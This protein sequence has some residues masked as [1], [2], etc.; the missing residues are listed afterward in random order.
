MS[1]Y[2]RPG[3]VLRL[4]RPFYG[5][6]EGLYVVS[7]FPAMGFVELRATWRDEDG[8]LSATSRAHRL[9]WEE[10]ASSVF[11]PLRRNLYCDA[12]RAEL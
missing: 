7:D 9:T 8:C 11:E 1:R 6:P 12:D 2:C 4:V 5:L 3:D 10:V